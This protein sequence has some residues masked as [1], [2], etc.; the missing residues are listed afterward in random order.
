MLRRIFTLIIIIALF[1]WGMVSLYDV[2]MQ[3]AEV[4]KNPEQSWEV[5]FDLIPIAACVIV[6]GALS[7]PFYLRARKEGRSWFK[8]MFLPHEFK[9]DDEREAAITAKATKASYSSMV[10]ATPFVTSLL[11]FYPHISSQVPYYPIIVCLLLPI[12][13]MI[14]YGITW[15]KHYRS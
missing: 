8:I 15:R 1:G 11:L 13:Q 6:G 4:L 3:F 10:I 12:I 14:T 9:E 2:Q 7:F 5:T